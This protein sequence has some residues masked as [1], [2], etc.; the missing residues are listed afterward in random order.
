VP[1]PNVINRHA[2]IALIKVRRAR[3]AY[4]LWLETD[5]GHVFGPGVYSLLRKIQ[6][7]GTLKEAAAS[8]GMSY[9]Y[10]WGLIKKAEEKLGEPLISATKGGRHGGGST[11][12]TEL[13]RR[14]VRDF[15]MFRRVLDEVSEGSLHEIQIK[16]TILYAA[17][18]GDAVEYI[19]ELRDETLTFTLP[20]GGAV[21]EAG[22]AVI[23]HVSLEN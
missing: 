17:E 7:K 16:G 9:R 2:E 11:E 3:P 4:K 13:G 6:E 19:I 5:E 15:E 14:Y 18:K 22:E 21:M 8:L 12:I 23:L 1:E 20:R 10:A